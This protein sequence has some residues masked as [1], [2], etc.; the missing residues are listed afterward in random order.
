MI[1]FI[2]PYTLTK[3]GSAGNIADL[4]ITVALALGFLFFTSRILA[5]DLSQSYWNFKSHVKFSCPNVISFL[6]LFCNCQFRRL[7]TQLSSQAHILAGLRLETRL[8]TSDYR[9]LLGRVFWLCHFITPRH[10]P[11]S[12]QR[13]Y[14]WQGLFTAPLPSNKRH[15]VARVDSG[16][17][18]ITNSLPSNG[19]IRYNMS[20]FQT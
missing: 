10:G 20:P 13:L 17:N 3:F 15:I 4:H 6:P 11:R 9:S 19:F 14:C 16:G 5:T 2:A 18:V 1:G 12:K 8:F 7:L